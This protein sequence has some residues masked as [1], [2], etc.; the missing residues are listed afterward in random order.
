MI[1]G[2]IDHE[3]IDPALVREPLQAI[4]AELDLEIAAHQPVCVLSGRCCKFAEYDHT[5]FVSAPEFALLLADAPA[6]SR[7]LDEGL[8]CPWQDLQGRCTAR[9]AR[10]LGC[11]VYFCD[12]KYE[13]HSGPITES[14]LAKVRDVC[15]SLALPWAYAPLHNHLRAAAE[16]G[17]IASR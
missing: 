7:P 6:P 11:R 15:D 10:P 8:T 2:P 17:R 16:S 9:E 3:P 4:Y 13:P 5:L 14:H 1:F 12:P